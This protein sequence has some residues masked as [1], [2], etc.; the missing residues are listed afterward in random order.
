LLFGSMDIE[1]PPPLPRMVGDDDA[2][3]C[4]GDDGGQ[5]EDW[6]M[7][8]LRDDDVGNYELSLI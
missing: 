5:M 7:F 2:D 4:T 1:E 6:G 8:M 3:E